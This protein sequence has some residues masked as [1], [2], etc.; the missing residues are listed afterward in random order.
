[1]I[2]LYRPYGYDGIRAS[3]YCGRSIDSKPIHVEN[4]ATFKELDTGRIYYYDR[5][6]NKWLEGRSWHGNA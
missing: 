2:T 4:G 3:A 6:N 5:E 1:M